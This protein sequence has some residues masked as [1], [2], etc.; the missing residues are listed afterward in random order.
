MTE[1]EPP[2][3]NGEQNIVQD[4]KLLSTNSTVKM[5]NRKVEG[6]ITY[7]LAQQVPKFKINCG[8]KESQ[9]TSNSDKLTNLELWG[10]K[11]D[12]HINS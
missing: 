3:E 4:N 5:E 1:F 6:L 9:E 7:S 2:K 10:V 11:P 8:K 12:F